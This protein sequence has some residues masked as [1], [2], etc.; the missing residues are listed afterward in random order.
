MGEHRPSRRSA[1][2]IRDRHLAAR[3]PARLDDAMIPTL[4][5]PFWPSRR[6]VQFDGWCRPAA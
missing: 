5:E 3:T 1:L 4:L 6:T 2:P